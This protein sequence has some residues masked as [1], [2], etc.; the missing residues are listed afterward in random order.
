MPFWDQVPLYKCPIL[1]LEAAELQL[2]S[3]ETQPD[4][5][6]SEL[7]C[8]GEPINEVFNIK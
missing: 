8:H 7:V 6:L 2:K 1:C 5:L 4:S 3:V